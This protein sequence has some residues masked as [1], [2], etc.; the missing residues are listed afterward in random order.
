MLH[1]FVVE[2]RITL[3][4]DNISRGSRH[5]KGGKRYGG[6]DIS[7]FG[8]VLDVFVCGWGITLMG[9]DMSGSWRHIGDV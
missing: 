8:G 6:K 2:G 4:G 9:K 7:R 1:A 3:V 5:G